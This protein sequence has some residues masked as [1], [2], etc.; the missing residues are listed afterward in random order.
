MPRARSLLQLVVLLLAGAVAF[1]ETLQ[2]AAG[3]G[4]EEEAGEAGWEE[5]TGD[6]PGDEERGPRR[7][8]GGAY[9]TQGVEDAAGGQDAGRVGAQGEEAGDHAHQQGE[10][11]AEGEPGRGRVRLSGAAAQEQEAAEDGG[12]YEAGDQADP[13]VDEGDQGKVALAGPSALQDQEREGLGEER[14]DEHEAEAEDGAHAEE[15]KQD[16]ALPLTARST[17]L[18]KAGPSRVPPATA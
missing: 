5:V 1:V 4:R 14:L 3:D 9:E 13:Y 17:S 7:E 8:V 2:Q 18:P 6:G 10:R 11:E 15:T 16:H 12:G